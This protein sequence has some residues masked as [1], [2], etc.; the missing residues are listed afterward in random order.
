M[1][2]I[3]TLKKRLISIFKIGIGQ[4]E[5]LD[6]LDLTSRGF[7]LSFKAIL[8]AIPI[9]IIDAAM[10]AHFDE[11]GHD[12]AEIIFGQSLILLTSWFLP[13]LIIFALA[14]MLNFK[15]KL[16]IFTIA[17]NWLQA[18]INLCSLPVSI[19]LLLIPEGADI[20][21]FPIL[22]LLI[23]LIYIS[24]RVF[25]AV[26]QE[27]FGFTIGLFLLYF[28]TSVLAEM[29]IIQLFGWNS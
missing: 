14:N 27:S 4:Y 9:L 5:R 22:F 20:L 11:K 12:L 3:E 16:I 1:L 8:V 24:F 6:E 7:W 25:D 15:S 26:L 23:F 2:D 18:F 10:S 21:L 19:L 28:L 17:Y 13:L 29:M